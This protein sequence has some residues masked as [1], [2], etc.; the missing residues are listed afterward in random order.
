MEKPK[1]FRYSLIFLIFASCISDIVTFFI[2]GLYEYEINP[3]VI[4]LKASIGMGWAVTI[5]IAFKVVVISLIALSIATY[6]PKKGGTHF[7]AYLVVHLTIA[8]ILLQILGTYANINTTIAYNENPI[9]TVPLAPEQTA[10]VLSTFSLIWYGVTLFNL[11]TFFI[12]E[13]IYR[14]TK[15]KK[16]RSA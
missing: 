11:L 12:Y 9:D 3:I 10:K 2:S 1:L 4:A 15:R 16:A 14:I 6:K 7:F 5:A 8:I 13:N